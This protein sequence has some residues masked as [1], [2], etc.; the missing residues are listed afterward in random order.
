MCLSSGFFPASHLLVGHYDHFQYC[1]QASFYNFYL[2][3]QN[4]L[5]KNEFKG[6]CVFLICYCSV[7]YYISKLNIFARF[8]ISIVLFL[9]MF[10]LICCFVF[11]YYLSEN[12]N[13]PSICFK[14]EKKNVNEN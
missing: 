4:K 7:C 13:C 3:V 14:M 9:V 8:L 12:F 10:Q 1:S 2:T 6:T 5:L 11:V